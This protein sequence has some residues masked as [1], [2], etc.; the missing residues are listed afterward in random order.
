MSHAIHKIKISE[1]LETTLR[2]WFLSPP[3]RSMRSLDGAAGLP[4]STRVH[5]GATDVRSDWSWEWR[6]AMMEKVNIMNLIKLKSEM[7]E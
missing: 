5:V 2:R 3:P 4:E 1:S 7:Y 6:E